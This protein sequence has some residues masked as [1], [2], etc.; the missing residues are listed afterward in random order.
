MPEQK[1]EQQEIVKRT[2][3]QAANEAAGHL[4]KT[5]EIVTSIAVAY[6]AAIKELDRITG[7]CK[8]QADTII[9]LNLKIDELEGKNKKEVVAQSNAK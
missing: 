3:S 9:K 7:I 1:A 2:G 4:F 5:G 6:D 8:N